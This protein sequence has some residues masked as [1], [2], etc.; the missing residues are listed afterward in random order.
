M[1]VGLGLAAP[2]A[3]RTCVIMPYGLLNRSSL[4]SSDCFVEP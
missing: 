3:S 1:T 2:H 4:S